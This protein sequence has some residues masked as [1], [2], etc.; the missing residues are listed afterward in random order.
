MDNNKSKEV[1]DIVSST[2]SP[3]LKRQLEQLH[4]SLDEFRYISAPISSEAAVA[5]ADHEGIKKHKADRD[6]SLNIDSRDAEQLRRKSDDISLRKIRNPSDSLN[7]LAQAAFN[8]ESSGTAKSNTGKDEVQFRE[9]YKDYNIDWCNVHVTNKQTGNE[10]SP[11]C[12]KTSPVS[13]DLPNDRLSKFCLIEKGILSPITLKTLVST[14]FTRHHQYMPIMPAHKI[15]KSDSELCAFAESEPILVI[16]FVIVASRFEDEKV[17]AASWEF[18]SKII[19]ELVLGIRKPTL[20]TIESFLILSENVPK[21]EE[22]N[23]KDLFEFEERFSWNLV[24]QAVRMSYYLGLDQRTLLET[25]ETMSEEARRMR[26]IWTCCYVEECQTSIR[27]GRAMW[28][29][30]PTLCFPSPYDC[31]SASSFHDLRTLI[32]SASSLEDLSSYMQALIDST[33]LMSNIHDLLYPSR[34]RT[35]SLVHLGD[36]HKILDEFTMAFASYKMTWGKK[37]WEIISLNE[38]IWV[39]FNYAKL[40]AYGFAFEAHMKRKADSGEKLEAQRIFPM[41][42][43][44][45]PDAKFIIEAKIAAVKILSSCADNLRTYGAMAYLPARYYGYFSHSAVFLIKILFTGA[46]NFEEQKEILDLIGR[47]ITCFCEEFK[48]LDRYHPLI[49]C[50]R[51]LRILLQTLWPMKGKNYVTNYDKTIIDH[52]TDNSGGETQHVTLSEDPLAGHIFNLVDN[53]SFDVFSPD[54][55]RESTEAAFQDLTATFSNDLN[56]DF[57]LSYIN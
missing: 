56:S 36:Y 9:Q 50:A 5:Y 49:R 16:T 29:R 4:S 2:E 45:N 34:D 22:I 37:C 17:H 53:F 41:S 3:K 27:F 14:F 15:L 10:K 35:I 30:G 57:W 13:A 7:L 44:A 19:Q 51:Q 48:G 24:G 47:V 52:T 39:S 12:L 8:D 21:C 43:M 46:V 32:P 31:H 54:I 20:G 1:K 42:M 11:G 23:D 33:N 28:S 6:S 40:Y 55:V 25:E 26:Y 18:M 38:T